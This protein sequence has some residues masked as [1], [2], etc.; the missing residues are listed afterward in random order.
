VDNAE[1]TRENRSRRAADRQGFILKKSPR[2]DPRAYDY[3]GWMIVD[4]FTNSVVAGGHP[5]GYSMSLE[6]VEAFLEGDE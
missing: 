6:D 1:K 3:N 2:R 5:H 4:K